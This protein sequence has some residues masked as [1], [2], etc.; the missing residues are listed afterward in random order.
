MPGA[1]ASTTA[2]YAGIG[3]FVAIVLYV[4]LYYSRSFNSVFLTR[5]HGANAAAGAGDGDGD[6]CVGAHEHAAGQPG[7]DEADG[8][9]QLCLEEGE[10]PRVRGA[11][12]RCV[13]ICS[14]W[15]RPGVKC[16]IT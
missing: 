11:C 14:S 15:S 13:A 2:Q 16:V 10:R 12:G 3:V 1:S 4:V 9:V 5:R 7:G 8:C 6:A